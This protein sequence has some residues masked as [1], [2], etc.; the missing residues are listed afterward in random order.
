MTRHA[1]STDSL[2]DA[3]E[4]NMVR[5]VVYNDQ[6]ELIGP[7]EM[8]KVV[9]S[10][11]DWRK[12]LSDEQYKIARGKG[13]ERPFCG[14]L[15]DNKLQGVYTCICCG[16]P[17]FS[18][19]SKF[20]SGTGWPSFFQPVAAQNIAEHMDDSLGVTRTEILCTRC[21]A[22]LG[23]VFGD[24]PRP[25]GLRYC[26]NSESLSF[27]PVGELHKLADPYLKQV[28]STP[29]DTTAVA[30]FAGGCFWCTEAVFEQI[31]GVKEVTSGYTGGTVDSPT[32]DYV[33]S[34][35]TGHAEAIQITYDPSVASYEDLL[36]VFFATHD[37]TQ[38]NR[39]G[40][41]VG[42]QYRSVV[43]YANQE[44]KQAAQGYIAKLKQDAAHAKPIV[45][46]VEPLT[47]FWPAEAYHQDY[48]RRNPDNPY[49]QQQALPKLDKLRVKF[50]QDVKE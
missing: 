33:T 37:P 46:T 25:T 34:G 7:V 38:L 22:H 31:K 41:D 36:K 24:G 50:P 44:Q 5:V 14:T 49:I 29:Q 3:K 32:Y 48:A 1:S 19:Q 16:L 27:A 28:R 35:K 18:S 30:V 8:P 20:N 6:G 12:Q 47:K 23:H 39:Q 40:P 4:S 15:L 26:V 42:T 17:L 21:D 13:T 45:T 43:F 9:K 10:D 11:A 2:L